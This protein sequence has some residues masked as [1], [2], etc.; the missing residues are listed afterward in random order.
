MVAR[1]LRAAEVRDL[2]IEPPDLEDVIRRIYRG[3]TGNAG[4]P[5]I[6]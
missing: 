2:S 4:T 1:V 6:R 5:E 3:E